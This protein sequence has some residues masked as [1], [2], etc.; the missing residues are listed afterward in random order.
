MAITTHAE[1]AGHQVYLQQ[2]WKI[3]GKE[4]TEKCAECIG[5]LLC[6]RYLACS[7]NDLLRYYHLGSNQIA[8]NVEQ[9]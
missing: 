6:I 2:D 7:N 5:K 1:P 4:Q 9:T 3:P 8:P